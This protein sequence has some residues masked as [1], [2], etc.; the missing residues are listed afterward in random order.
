MAT[1]GYVTDSS[2][3]EPIEQ[4][5]DQSGG[6]EPEELLVEGEAGGSLLD[7][8]QMQFGSTPWWVISSIVHVVAFL[9]VFVLA[10]AIAPPA[11]DDEVVFSAPP[12]QKK[13]PYNETLKRDLFKK[14]DA[15]MEK[16]I[17]KPMVVQDPV[18]DDHFETDKIGR[19]H[20]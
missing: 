15:P 17:D 18:P 16:V 8:L 20:V 7:A 2:A 14:Q 11:T 6:A 10:V 13:D 12:Q 19:A 4:V 9:L 3:V 5:H 1:G